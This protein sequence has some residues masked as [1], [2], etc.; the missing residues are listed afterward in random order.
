MSHTKNI[1]HENDM[2]FITHK[3]SFF[4]NNSLI[5]LIREVYAI[6]SITTLP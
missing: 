2:Q 6:N 4:P 3:N 1:G 5:A